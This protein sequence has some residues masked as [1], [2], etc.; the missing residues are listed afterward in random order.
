MA[1]GLLAV[2]GLARASIIFDTGPVSNTV[3]PSFTNASNRAAQ[4]SLAT[5][6]TVTAIERWT[7]VRTS[8][9][10]RLRIF[11]DG[12]G[13]PVTQLFQTTFSVAAGAEDWIGVGGLDWVLSAGTYWLV[14]SPGLVIDGP[15]AAFSTTFCAPA[16][17]GVTCNINNPLALEGNLSFD[18]GQNKPPTLAP[19]SGRT[20]WRMAGTAV[21]EPGSFALLGLGLLVVGMTRRKKAA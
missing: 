21:P 20:G 17:N 8:G 10:A 19:A 13:I 15:T 16:E 5:E 1:M 14:L 2:S 6:T 4:F 3:S 18:N 9:N 12:G 7:R 11:T